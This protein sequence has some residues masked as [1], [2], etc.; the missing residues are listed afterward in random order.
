MPKIF[1]PEQL[2]LS[3]GIPVILQHCESPV[4]ATYWWIKTGSADEA[5]AEAGFA[6][7]LE[8]MLFKDAAAKDTGRASTGKM[9][10]AIESLGGDINAYTSFDQTVYHVTSAAHHWERVIDAFGAMA[11]PQKFLKSDFDRERE[12]ILEELR[13]NE[14][15]PGRKL[16]QKL[17]SLTFKKHPYGK[18]VIGYIK[19]LKA[20]R[21][22]QLEAFY[23]RNYVSGKM[24][25]VLVGPVLD[26]SGARKKSILKYLEKHF[27]AKV[28]PRREAKWAP[29]AVDVAISKLENPPVEV[30]PFDVKTPTL[31]VSFRAPELTHE[32]TPA[33][34]LLAGILGMGELSRLYQRLFYQTS[35][36]TEV[37]GG[38]YTPKDPGML[39]FQAEVG[40]MD[41][42][43]P[44]YEEIFREL[45][46]L[47]DEGPTAEE[48]ARVI[49]N[50]E[51]EKLYATQTAD[52][53]AGR[54]GFLKFTL[55]DMDYDEKYIHELRAIDAAR[56]CEIAARY[57]DP[58]RMSIVLQIPKDQK[59]DFDVQEISEMASRILGGGAPATEV[60]K[61]S[62]SKNSQKHSAAAEI[63]KLPSGMKIA[64][65]DRPQSHVFSVHASVLGGLR[66]ELA[67]PVGTP[68]TDW[69]SSH[70]MAMTWTKGT[71]SIKSRA[72]RDAREIASIVE[73]SAA[74]MDGF[75][76]RNSVGLQMTGLARDWAKLSDLFADVLVAPSFPKEEIEHSRRVTEDTIRGIEDHSSQLCSKLFLETLYEQHPY[77]KMTYG[78]LESIAQMDSQK[79]QAIH[80]QWIRPE[81]L[82]LAVSGP[83][84]RGALDGWLGQ[85]EE[86]IKTMSLKNARELPATLADESPLK[87]P[88]WVDKSLGREQTHILVGGLGTKIFSED[89]HAI[90]L[91]QTILGGQSGRLFIEL[92]EKKSLAYTV[93]PVSFEGLERGYVGTYIACA[94]SKK[95]EALAGIRTVLEKLAAQGPSAAEMSR[96]KEFFLGRRAMEMQSDSAIAAHMGLETLYGVEHLEESKLIKKIH[97]VTARE[98]QKVCR[99]YL[100]EPQ[101]VTSIVG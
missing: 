74:G 80:A 51:S 94:P 46:K 43:K 56:V 24:G 23:R 84:R 22:T 47:R 82:T 21:V 69:G 91:L 75:S 92:R 19:T 83:I 67:A 6:H 25:L 63:F 15:S 18:P 71:H 34:D 65:F 52:G 44:A 76:G 100:I 7:F 5:P 30:V 41:K 93:A 35:I 10:R 61:K 39:Y 42:I 11:K 79:L 28:L 50:A 98:V 1:H 33:L 64:F 60:V 54:L 72:A 4:A 16:F 59:L 86:R 89:R 53:L 48:L 12:V 81:R 90:R 99:Q 85:L 26:E 38:L 29:R 32:D 37:S 9:A 57:L 73:G 78:S 45:K 95:D 40:S 13:K 49:V 66:M 14:D 36:A 17:F 55:E 3:N 101:M 31:S 87:A 2:E 20:A 62:A 27:G 77:G 68:Q 88:R 96:S 70:L 8:H 97:A 58:R